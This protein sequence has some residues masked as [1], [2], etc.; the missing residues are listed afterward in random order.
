MAPMAILRIIDGFGTGFSLKL[1]QETITIGRGGENAVQIGDPKASR[2]HAE[3][4]FVDGQAIGFKDLGSSNGTWNHDGSIDELDLD[5][6]STFRIGRTYM[7][8][9]KERSQFRGTLLGDT[10]EWREPGNIQ[11]LIPSES[12]LMR[13]SGGNTSML[14]AN[15]YLVLLHQVVLG[16]QEGP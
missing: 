7:R 16:S 15:T 6:G 2:V 8:L 3:I 13:R 4:S 1:N 5:D 10:G 11:R 12:Q 9:E 14:Q